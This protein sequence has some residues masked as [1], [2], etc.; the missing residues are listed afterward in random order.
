[1]ARDIKR[2][3]HDY[4]PKYY[5]DSRVVANLIEREAE[6]FERL[7]FSI[8]DVLAQLCVDTA[9][10]GLD[11]WEAIFDL[12]ENKYVELTWDM[13]E[14]NVRTFDEMDSYTW[15]GLSTASFLERPYEERRAAIKARMRGTGTVTKQLIKEVVE[16]YT[17]GEVEV[18]EDPANYLVTIKF[19][20]NVGVPPNYESAKNA[21]L[22]IIPAHIGVQFTNEYTLW[23]DLRATTWGN[24]A[25]YSW[26]DVKGGLWNA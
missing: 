1:M 15:D 6:E 24:L 25:T 26:A 10:W 23:Q 17:N 8:Q 3:M 21:V 16:S 4:L 7:G 14:M 5:A 19:V 18:I 12:T 11:R 20:S 9:T 13:V 22:E 2:D